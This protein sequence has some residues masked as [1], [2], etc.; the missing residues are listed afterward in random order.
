MELLFPIAP[1][2]KIMAYYAHKG[3]FLAA[4]LNNVVRLIGLFG[5]SFGA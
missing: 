5:K 3:Q 1:W 2:G 4:H